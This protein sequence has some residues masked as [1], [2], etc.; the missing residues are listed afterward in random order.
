MVEAGSLAIPEQVIVTH[1][2]EPLEDGPELYRQ[3]AGPRPGLV[4]VLFAP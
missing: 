3:F 4:K 1:P 2:G